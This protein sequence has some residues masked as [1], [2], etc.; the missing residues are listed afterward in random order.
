[1]GFLVPNDMVLILSS[2]IP[3]FSRYSLIDSVLSC[4]NLLLSFSS[5]IIS[6]YP[7]IDIFVSGYWNKQ[8]IILFKVCFPSSV[9]FDEL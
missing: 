8:S 3:L 4:D 6:A 9:I 5:L 1:M 2:E 7:F